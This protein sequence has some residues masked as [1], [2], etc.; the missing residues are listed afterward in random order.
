M[1]YDG[2]GKPGKGVGRLAM[3]LNG[4]PFAVTRAVNG[5]PA[6][7]AS[8]GLAPQVGSHESCDNHW[9]RSGT[10]VLLGRQ[11]PPGRKQNTADRLILMGDWRDSFVAMN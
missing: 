5:S 10:N 11:K 9:T 8:E 4:M 6:T 3:K 2:D 7:R 1:S